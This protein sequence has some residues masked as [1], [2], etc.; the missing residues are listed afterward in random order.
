[1]K[2]IENSLASVNVVTWLKFSDRF[3]ETCNAN[4]SLCTRLNKIEFRGRKQ[5]LVC[6]PMHRGF[7]QKYRLTDRDASFSLIVC[8]YEEIMARFVSPLTELFCTFIQL[9]RFTPNTI[10]KRLLYESPSLNGPDKIT[11]RKYVIMDTETK[12]K[13]W[14]R[15]PNSERQIRPLVREGAHQQNR[16]N[17]P[18]GPKCGLTL[19]LADWTSIVT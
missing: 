7:R 5:W 10:Q 1:M 15:K 12:A 17:L 3:V 13:G 14:G 18:M 6:L 8:V 4:L 9:F 2:F 16:K 11:R 19:K